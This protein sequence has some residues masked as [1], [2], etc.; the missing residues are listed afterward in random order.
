MTTRPGAP[1]GSSHGAERGA[2][3]LPWTN[4]AIGDDHLWAFLDPVDDAVEGLWEPLRSN[5][6]L[7]RLFV[8]ATRAGEHGTVWLGLAGLAA[9]RHARRGDRRRAAFG[10]VRF[11]AALSVESIVVNGVL[12][13]ITRRGR[14]SG[15]AERADGVRM[16]MTS[17]MPSGHAT[18]SML[19]AS[20][21][22][23]EVESPVARAALWSGAAAVA[24]S[25]VH[26]RIHHATDVGAGAIIGLLAGRW[27][28]S[29]WPLPLP[30]SRR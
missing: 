9:A 25:R 20:L 14:P 17:S 16:P 24:W 27:V 29:R 22:S 4:A 2:V 26:V 13:S 21:L 10:L 6:T 5:P 30:Q 7:T 11:V 19:A 3:R 12:K 28:R 15:G 8:V 1:D 18:S 23:D